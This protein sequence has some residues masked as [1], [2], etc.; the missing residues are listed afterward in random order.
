[1]KNKTVVTYCTGGIRCEKAAALMSNLGFK[2]V[3]QL[4]GGI[5][6][7]FE[8]CGGDFFDGECFVFDKRIAVDSAL[9]ETNTIQCYACRG[10]VTQEKQPAGICPY[11]GDD[12]IADRVS[13]D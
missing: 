2:D 11:C 3:Y 7:Y 8:Q 12:N 4:D 6:N 5:L 9:N 1:M 13:T 10:P